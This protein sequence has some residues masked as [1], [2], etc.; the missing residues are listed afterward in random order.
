MDNLCE[1]H[2]INCQVS[3]TRRKREKQGGYCQVSFSQES[4][5]LQATKHNSNYLATQKGGI[6]KKT[7]NTQRDTKTRG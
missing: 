5:P 2:T 6:K 1:P 4:P 7:S 3:I